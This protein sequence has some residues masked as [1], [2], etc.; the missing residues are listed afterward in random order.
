V[1]AYSDFFGLEFGEILPGKRSSNARARVGTAG[2]WE[3]SVSKTEGGFGADSIITLRS[4]QGNAIKIRN[5]GAIRNARVRKKAGKVSPGA[6][7]FLNVRQ[8]TAAGKP[9]K[10]GKVTSVP[11]TFKPPSRF[12]AFSMTIGGNNQYI[13]A[14][15]R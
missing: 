8:L 4:A 6:K 13:K 14:F 7:L 1:S 15:S 11:F 9:V 5:T 2:E 3:F 12:V 10:D